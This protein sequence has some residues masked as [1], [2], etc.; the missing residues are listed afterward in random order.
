MGGGSADAAA[1]LRMAQRLSPIDD[2]TL[3]ELAAELGSDVPSQLTPGLVLGTGAGDEVELRSPIA[4]HAFVIVPLPHRLSAAAV[5]AEA[6]RLGVRGEGFE[7]EAKLPDLWSEL[8][9]GLRLPERLL[10]NELEAAARSLCPEIE[11][12]LGAVRDAGADHAFVSGSGP[13]VAGLFWAPPPPP[14]SPGS[15]APPAP[16]AGAA[17]A[18]AEAAAT[19]LGHRYPGACC[20]V[21]V[22]RDFGFPLFA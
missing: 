10:V 1:V 20:A 11:S 8:S 19:A 17:L 16:P 22:S 5:Y 6:D 3:G 18:R 7:V 13:T 21:P 9:R 15:P 2:E 4:E 14:G 12:A